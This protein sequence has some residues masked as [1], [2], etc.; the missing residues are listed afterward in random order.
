MDPILEVKQSLETSVAAINLL[1]DEVKTATGR[2]DDLDA[3]SR[4]K[5]EK[6]IADG[7]KALEDIQ[8]ANAIVEAQGKEQEALEKRI[9]EVEKKAARGGRQTVENTL[10]VSDYGKAIDADLRQKFK[11]PQ[12]RDLEFENAREITKLFCPH[13]DGKQLDDFVKKAVVSGSGPDGGYLVPIERI[14]RM[15]TQEFETSPMVQLASSITIGTN[16]VKMPI[17]DEEVEVQTG[18]EVTKPITQD[19]PQLGLK[20]IDV[21]AVMTRLRVSEDMIDDSGIDIIGWMG[22][23]AGTRM[24]RE[25]NRQGLVGNN[26]SECEGLLTLPESADPDVY[27]RGTIGVVDS[28][29]GGAS[30]TIVADDFFNVQSFVK[31]V[32]RPGTTWM[33]KRR[34]F[35]DVATLKDADGQYLMR[36]GDALARGIGLSLVGDPIFFGDDMPALGSDSKSFLYGNINRTYL[37]VNRVGISLLVDPYSEDPLIRYRW[38]QRYGGGVVNFEACKILR[39]AT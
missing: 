12:N 3:V 24:G 33:M 35:F 25:K 10:M 37:Y 21:N 8:K 7:G 31:E 32:Y 28:L 38:R 34:S 11:H 20:S 39:A 19:N 14:N 2:I 1:R 9:A 26:A 27:Q 30:G 29:S 17:D 6:A 5:V 23:K 15:I 16:M 4:D 22:D 13:L 18:G 36:F